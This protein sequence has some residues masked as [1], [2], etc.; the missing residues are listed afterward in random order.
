MN[1]KTSIIYFVV[2]FK[3]REL[4]TLW[5]FPY[6]M[7]P[8]VKAALPSLTMLDYKVKKTSFCITALFFSPLVSEPIGSSSISCIVSA[9]N[10]SCNNSFLLPSWKLSK[11]C[12]H[13]DKM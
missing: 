12:L 10:V 8:H 9:F 1:T 2:E 11:V 3:D 6:F 4:P 7:E 5:I 13:Y